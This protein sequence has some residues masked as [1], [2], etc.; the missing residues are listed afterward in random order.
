M[1][2]WDCTST[3]SSC[4]FTNNTSDS[5][6]GFKSKGGDASTITNCDFLN[7]STPQTGG[8]AACTS[9]TTLFDGCYFENNSA[10]TWG[11]GAAVDFANDGVSFRNCNFAGNNAG[12]SGGGLR[13]HEGSALVEKCIFTSNTAPLGGGGIVVNGNGSPGVCTVSGSIFEDNNGGFGFGGGIHHTYISSTDVDTSTFCGNVALPITG[14]WNDLGGNEMNSSCLFF[15]GGDIDA[16]G[17][18]NVEDI[19]SLLSEW[20][21]CDGI[22]SCFS[23]QNED[24]VVDVND[25][26]M[27]I[28]NWGTCE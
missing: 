12:V 9:S 18:V 25:L 4:T 3:V 1:Y 22:T 15:C 13:V 14:N 26:L 11:G 5:G 24:G 7:N 27:L 28:A 8:G 17:L 2:L 21:P 20:G 19:L 10:K 16:N 6:G 23:D